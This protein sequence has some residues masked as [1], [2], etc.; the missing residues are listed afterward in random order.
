MKILRYALL[1]SLMLPV[2]SFAQETVYVQSLKAKLLAA[3]AFNAG[4]VAEANR[5]DAA[6]V[7]EIQDRWY[8]VQ[9]GDKSGWLSRLVVSD[10]APLNKATALDEQHTGDV[11]A[12]RRASVA[13]TAGAA[14]GLTADDRLRASQSG[15]TNYVALEKVEKLTVSEQEALDFLSEGL[16]Q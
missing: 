12:R 14:R 16:K 2:A 15:L 5:G 9:L 4:V 7:L 1:T 8:K 13:T 10:H 6:K 11:S 3:P